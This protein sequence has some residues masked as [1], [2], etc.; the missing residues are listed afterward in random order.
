MNNFEGKIFDWNGSWNGNFWGSWWHLTSQLI[1]ELPQSKLFNHAEE[2]IQEVELS[3]EEDQN[4][5]EIQIES[6]T[7]DYEFNMDAVKGE[8][9]DQNAE[10]QEAEENPSGNSNYPNEPAEVALFNE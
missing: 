5:D 6:S 1:L 8:I 3:F 10:Q 9:L 7:T 2:N 4:Y